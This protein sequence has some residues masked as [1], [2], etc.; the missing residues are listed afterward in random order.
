MEVDRKEGNMMGMA[1][2]CT[3]HLDGQIPRVNI[4]CLQTTHTHQLE[5]SCTFKA[6]PSLTSLSFDVL[7]K[8]KH[9]VTD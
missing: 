6:T 7:F 8:I 9:L 1:W 5:K 3:Q 4:Y 2:Y